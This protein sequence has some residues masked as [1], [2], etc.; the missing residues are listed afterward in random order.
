MKILSRNDNV[1]IAVLPG[2]TLNLIVDG[3][4]VLSE[5][6][7]KCMYIDTVMAVAIED[8]DLGLKTGIAGVFGQRKREDS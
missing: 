3:K 7:T 2:D 4:V 8:G 1:R 5:P 6:I